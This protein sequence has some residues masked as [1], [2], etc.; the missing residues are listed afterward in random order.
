MQVTTA[1]LESELAVVKAI[2]AG[3]VAQ[4][5]RNLPDKII[6]SPMQHKL[7]GNQPGAARPARISWR[8]TETP[9]DEFNGVDLDP[10]PLVTESC[11]PQVPSACQVCFH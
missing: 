10:A 1:Q 6:S 5:A 3:T 7:L 9:L 4:S 11:N 8:F 2:S